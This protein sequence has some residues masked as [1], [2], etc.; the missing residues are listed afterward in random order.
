M[1]DG[2]RII[3]RWP[4]EPSDTI[5][6]AFP[7]LRCPRG[8]QFRRGADET[9]SAAARRWV[10]GGFKLLFYTRCDGEQGP[11]QQS[12][13]VWFESIE[14]GVERVLIDRGMQQSTVGGG[15]RVGVTQQLCI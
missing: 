13:R 6:D 14:R 3:G 7:R 11:P 9:A 5:A 2:L 10:D 8:F 1:S 15:D 4:Q 12:V